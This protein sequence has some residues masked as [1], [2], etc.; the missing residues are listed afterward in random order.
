MSPSVFAPGPFRAA[1]GA[2]T[3]KRCCRGR[4]SR[5]GRSERAASARIAIRSYDG[6]CAVPEELTFDHPPAGTHPPYSYPDYKSTVERAPR[7]S[8]V[9]LPHT[10]SELTGP[11]YG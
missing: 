6:R 8:L 9:L 1:L 5:D 3:F 2:R 4:R 11:V 10:L 7:E